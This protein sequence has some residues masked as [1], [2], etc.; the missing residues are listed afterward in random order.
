MTAT[1][2]T[3]S[4]D[5]LRR[6]AMPPVRPSVHH[7]MIAP[8]GA[9]RPHA[10]AYADWLAGLGPD[11][12]SRAAMDL[13]QARAES[14]IAFAANDT[15]AAADP[16]PVVMSAK[17]WHVLEAAIR[18]RAELAE[19]ALADLYGGG[20]MVAGGHL[21]PGIVYG[22]PAFAAQAAGWEL[23]PERFLYVYE[24]DV[25]RTAAGDWIVLSDRVDAPLGD[26]W[27]I[28]NRIA[29]SQCFAQ[30]FLDLGVRRL[31]SHY[32]R[33]Q[34]LLDSLTGWEGR[35]ALLTRGEQDPRFFSH[36][37][38]ARYL[39]A[40]LV[41]PGDVT[42]RE[43][44]AFVKTL[45]GLK[46]IDV[47]L[48]G[49]PD[50][51]VDALH[52]QADALPGAPA[53]TVAA[54]SGQLVMGNAI[55]SSVLGH[56]ALAP[57]AHVLAEQLI[58]EELAIADAP[59]LW[60]GDAAARAEVLANPAAWSVEPLHRRAMPADRARHA[61]RDDLEE[62]VTRRGEG[63][64]ATRLPP[65]AETAVQRDGRLASAPWMMRVF[66]CWT[67]EAW[68][69]APG[70][71][72]AVIAQDPQ[73]GGGRIPELGFGKDVWI[74]TDSD[75]PP[76]GPSVSLLADR[77]AQGHLRRTG[78]DLLSRVADEVFWLGRNT[79][80]AEATLRL[81]LVCLRR[82]LSGNRID[83]DPK[84]LV[85]LITV[86]AVD[87]PDLSPP[88]RFRDAVTRLI[89]APEEP[90]GLPGTLAA[91][92]S[93]MVRA[94]LSISEEGWRTIDLLCSD[95]R[96]SEG[97]D[98]RRSADLLRLLEDSLR[99][100]AAFSGAAQ[101]N[102]T[103]NY[104][105][106]FLE[107]GRRI[108]RGVGIAREAR[109]IIHRETGDEDSRLRAWLTLSDSSAAY[110]NRYMMMPRAAAVLDLL[111]LDES[112]PRALAFQLARLE[113]VLA[114]LPNDGP[115]RSP[116]HRLALAMLTELRLLDAATL[117]ETDADGL[118]APLEALMNSCEN[119]LQEISDRVARRFFAH[120]APPVAV[121]HAGRR[122]PVAGDT[123]D[124]VDR[125]GSADGGATLDGEGG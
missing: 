95:R 124:G 7:E 60:M 19:L 50:R 119:S 115:Y 38:L 69:V 67:G 40:A 17:D 113:S 122:D 27:L 116:E 120:A 99:S 44:A 9:P 70:G 39:N 96:W 24:A 83:A 63:L 30:P 92:R 35:L 49:A 21:P 33:F 10:R 88:Q 64:V 48:R 108:E 110:R 8:D 105:W 61:R 59:C 23:P 28:A 74:I 57:F 91:L 51:T 82:Y 109:A 104:A 81:T 98:L 118:R 13:E 47:M 5:R 89:N 102:L 34:E 6:A 45:D 106:R 32:A 85:D 25:A 41:E 3:L 103:R 22:S 52:R 90:F 73:Q 107:L 101:E 4:A 29:T 93:G 76:S 55:G 77:L 46:K 78:R 53:L 79:E 68:S 15:G 14:G 62:A 2:V 16:L 72:A 71:V 36:A 56:R 84:L 125:A 97:L 31:A 123:A 112:N 12:L 26:G 11:G 100:L 121:S 86:R 94:R 18:Q 37:Y 80:R 117:A 1:G 58:G 42:V 65:L 114:D 87:R 66:A 75:E 20:R 54:R 111:V 43:G